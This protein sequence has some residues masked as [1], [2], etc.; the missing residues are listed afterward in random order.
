METHTGYDNLYHRP[1]VGRN[2]LLLGLWLRAAF[3]GAAF[4]VAGIAA[5]LATPPALPH[6]TALAWVAV[7]GTVGWLAWERARALLDRIDTD[8]AAPADRERSSRLRPVARAPA[9]P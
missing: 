9:S 7:G 4:A 3:I 6:V 2:V 8:E 1:A 5:L